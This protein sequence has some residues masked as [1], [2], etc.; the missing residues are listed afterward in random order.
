MNAEEMGRLLGFAAT[1]DNRTVGTPEVI[2]WLE[3]IGDLPFDDA[4]KAVATHYGADPNARLM[5]GHVRVG[6]K[7]IRADRLARTPLPAPSPE[8]ADDSV[9]YRETLAASIQSIANGKQVNRAIAASAPR[10][11]GG[12][13]AGEMAALKARLFAT[14]AHIKPKLSPEEMAAEQAEESRRERGAE[15]AGE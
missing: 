4:R 9:R 11:T 6:V 10:G 1:Y 7:A 5:P 8:L 12:L 15:A 14:A 13:P 2:A 3:A